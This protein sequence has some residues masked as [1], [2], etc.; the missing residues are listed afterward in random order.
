MRIDEIIGEDVTEKLYN[1]Y[2]EEEAKGLIETVSSKE[3]HDKLDKI[4][5]EM[6]KTNNIDKKTDNTLH[7]ELELA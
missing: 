6:E 2:L 5:K 3:E 4:I 7:N 1:Y